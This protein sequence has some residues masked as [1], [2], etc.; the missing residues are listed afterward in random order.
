[1]HQC[2]IGWNTISFA[3]LL[4]LRSDQWCFAM[5][6]KQG[7]HP[8]LGPGSWISL[9]DYQL[10]FSSFA[11]IWIWNWIQIFNKNWMLA[12]P[13]ELRERE[14]SGT[15][16]NESLDWSQRNH[17][18]HCHFHGHHHVAVDVAV[19]VA[20]E[21]AMAVAVAMDV[22]MVVAMAVAVAVAI[23]V[24]VDYELKK[25]KK[26]ELKNWKR[27]IEREREKW[28]QS[29][30][31][32]NHH[33]CCHCGHGY[34]HGHHHGH[35]C[36]HLPFLTFLF[37]LNKKISALQKKWEKILPQTKLRGFFNSHPFTLCSKLNLISTIYILSYVE[38]IHII[39]T[40]CY[41]VSQ[42][43]LLTF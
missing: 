18:C 7:N 9:Q 37:S 33:H 42:D 22:A 11:G 32:L 3:S 35:C 24:D 25:K 29:K 5:V 26:A 30:W 8:P 23:V 16:P 20:V 41:D 19:N 28:N 40:I 27:E 31:G 38:K 6:H 13:F 36:G 2:S 4:P 15:N 17:C 1:M 12:V 43:I 14:K 10:C 21:V 34:C 39:Y